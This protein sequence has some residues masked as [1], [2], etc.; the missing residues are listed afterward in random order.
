MSVLEPDGK[1]FVL[2]GEYESQDTDGAGYHCYYRA[3][4]G[5][6]ASKSEEVLEGYKS[7]IQD[8]DYIDFVIEEVPLIG[9]VKEE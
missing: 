8:T 2:L 1:V 9:W 5:I 3:M 4:N 7:T 6:A